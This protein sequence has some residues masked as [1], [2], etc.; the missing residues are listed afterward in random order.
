M[1][2]IILTLAQ[3]SPTGGKPLYDGALSCQASTIEAYSLPAPSDGFE[4]SLFSS[5]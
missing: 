1:L 5:Y 2:G 4:N 3:P